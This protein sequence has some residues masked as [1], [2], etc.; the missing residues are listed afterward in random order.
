M[1]KA[2]VK[3][4]FEEKVVPKLMEQFNYKNVMQVPKIEKI[5][6][7][8]R[9]GDSIQNKAFLDEALADLIKISGQAPS[10][11]K[12]KLSVANFKLRKGMP[13]GVAVTLRKN[14]MWEFFDR[15]VNIAI[16]RV[17]DFRGLNP[18]GFD[19]YGNYNFGIKE[20]IIFPEIDY[21]KVTKI[22]G[23]DICIVTTAKTDDEAF[24]LLKELG[25]PFRK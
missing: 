22:R 9:C 16:P 13:V 20:H 12:A 24:F 2:R 5:I 8:M 3:K 14:R 6:V 18:K 21:D 15:L 4:I 19:S 11:R 23:M 17:R 1:E 7:N 25:V 10:I